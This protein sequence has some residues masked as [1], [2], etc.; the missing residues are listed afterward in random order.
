MN[1]FRELGRRILA[2]PQRRQFDADLDEEM[3]LHRELRTQEEIERSLLPEE[4]RH[5]AQRRFGDDLVSRE[6]SRDMWRWNWL[7]SLGQDIRYGLRMLKKNPGFTVVAVLTLALGIGAAT[8]MFSVIEGAMFDPFPYADSRRLAVIV[9]RNPAWGP[10]FFWGWHPVQDFLEFRKHNDVFDSIIGSRHEDCVLTGLDTPLG[11]DCLQATGN[12][13][14]VTGVAPLLGRVFTPTDALPGAPPVAVLRYTTWQSK[15]GGDPKI[16][17]RTLI[18]NAKPRTVIGVMPP[19]FGW[20]RADLWIPE[21]FSS[22]EEATGQNYVSAVGH[23]KPGVSI[24]QAAAEV[25]VLF[26]GYIAQ[27]PKAHPQGEEFSAQL[28]TVAAVGPNPRRIFWILFGAVGLLFTIGC[29]NVANL[30]L[31][32]AT[33]RETEIAIRATLGAGH[34]RLVRQLLAE[35]LLLGVAGALAGCVFAWFGL[36]VVMAIVPP[37]EIPNEA[38]IRINGLVLLFTASVTLVA[39]LLFGLAPALHA[40]RKDIQTPLRSGGRGAGQSR[41]QGCLRDLLVV[42][43]VALSLV[44]MTGAGL[45]M[46]SFLAVRYAKLGYEP[47]NLLNIY[48]RLPESRYGTAEQRNAFNAEILRRLQALPGVVSA[49][50][51]DSLPTFSGLGAAIEIVGRPSE[52][53]WQAQIYQASEGLFATLRVPLLKGRGISEQDCQPARKVAVINH[54][55]ATRYL[56]GENPLG[57]QIMVKGMN[58]P[59]GINSPSF[60]IIG[61]A[62]DIANNPGLPTQPAVCIPYTTASTPWNYCLV[63]TA[64]P[65]RLLLNPVRKAVAA[66]DK[67][68]PIRGEPLVDIL[69]EEYLTEPRFVLTLMSVFASLGLAL[70]LIGVYGVLSYSVSQRTHEI[71]LRMALGASVGDVLRM[72]MRSGLHWLLIGIGL[73]V[74]ASL[75]LAK[76]LQNRIWGLR[77][78]DPVTLVIVAILL[79]AAGLAACYVP[80]RRAT[81]VD[82]MVALRYE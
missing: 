41:S 14:Q 1:W 55:L 29:L 7:G 57:A 62:G 48:F 6:A 22:G 34:G 44:L 73:G 53:N 31:T 46:R 3:R 20:Q 11:F 69:S 18:L 26:K 75:A 9:R 52:G 59:N 72:L 21:T 39:T 42:S 66:L 32:R 65:P 63:R 17:G 45:L 2:L 15:F 68:L 64:I 30:L 74:P 13:F 27:S 54:S 47:A 36:K 58:P 60:E 35:S 81:K 40:V 61:V 24:E 67:E 80:A 23:L 38:V 79:T 37:W 10:D 5:A 49:V 70:V 56:S 28:L 82:P 25:A 4:A 12:F 71:G 8:V 50:V 19:R 16:V 78:A 77:A 51:G 33:T 76:A 43:E